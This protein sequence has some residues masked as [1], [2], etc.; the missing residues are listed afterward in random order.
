MIPSDQRHLFGV[1]DLE[2]E[3]ERDHLEAVGQKVEVE[4][5]KPGVRQTGATLGV[6]QVKESRVSDSPV[7]AAIDIIAEEEIMHVLEIV[8]RR[9]KVPEEAEQVLELPMQVAEDFTRRTHGD[10]ARVRPELHK[11]VGGVSHMG[12]NGVA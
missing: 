12:K 1:A 3:E 9:D 10:E 2:G 5:G 11:K 4:H 8:S 6:P 7:S